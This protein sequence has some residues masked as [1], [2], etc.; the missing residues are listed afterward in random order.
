V[1]LE[2]SGTTL[3]WETFTSELLAGNALG[4]PVTRRF[5]VLLPPG[6][7][8]GRRYATLYGLTG[9]LGRGAMLLNE[10]AWG[11]T[12]QDRLDRLFAAGMPP[13]IVVLPD[14]WTRFGGSQYVNSTATG[15]YED[16]VTRELVPYVDGSYSTIASRD[17]RGVFGKSSGGYGALIMGMRHAD[18][19]GAVACHSGD[20]AFDLSLRCDF[21]RAASAIGRAGGLETWWRSFEARPKK[22]GPEFETIMTVAMAACYSP[23]PQAPLGLDLPF[24]TDTCELRAE[25]WARWLA[26]DPI[27]LAER[28]A[29]DLRSLRLLYLDCGNRDEHHLHFGARQLARRLTTL[30]IPHEY[31]EFDDGHRDTDYRYDVSLPK[32]A[33]TLTADS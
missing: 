9:Y 2:P 30:G 31:D 16:Y 10:R 8:T 19:F 22:P 25:V 24:D 26:A 13:A 5:P 32:L 27:Q 33:R 18:L 7:D 28:H 20:M 4:D 29:D 6:Y 17:G 14:C 11:L 12:L 15:A 1:Q 3:V 23:N 21:P